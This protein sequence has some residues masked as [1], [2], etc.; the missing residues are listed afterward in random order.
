[1]SY[2][3]IAVEER[4]LLGALLA[5]GWRPAW[6]AYVLGRHRSTVSREIRRNR[7]RGQGWYRAKLADDY[8]RTRRRRTRQHSQFTAA[9]W[10]RIVQR[11]EQ[12]LS[13]EQIAGALRREGD[14]AISHETIYRYVRAD[15]RNAGTLYLQLRQGRRKR[16]KW[17]GRRSPRTPDLGKRRID[18]RPRVVETRRQLGHWEMDTILGPDQRGPCLLSLV[19]RVSGYLELGC[20][21]TKS[22]REVN[23]RAI[24]L[25]RA[26]P[27]PVRSITADNGSEFH[28]FKTLERRI[29]TRIYFATPHHAWE[30]GTNENTNGLVRQYLPK[31][32]SLEALTQQRCREIA[33][34]LNQRPRK[35]LGF[36]TPEERY[37]P[38]R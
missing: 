26:Q 3:Q 35:R 31:G 9:Q 5:L 27:R 30:R 21:R 11:L 29:G 2:S 32:Q 18:E 22:V 17:Y 33:R 8:A 24:Q 4:Y 20:L 6:I 13:P 38:K 10:Q 19:E 34:A 28:G 7:A 16:R 37:V 1:M 25:L 15:R 12:W 23:A 36:Q 14:F